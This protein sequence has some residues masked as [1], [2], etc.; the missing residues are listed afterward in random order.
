VAIAALAVI[1]VISIEDSSSSSAWGAIGTAL[2]WGSWLV[3]LAEVVVMLYLV[4]DRKAWIVRH[5]LDVAITVL[6]PPFLPFVG[7]RLLRLLRVLR[8]IFGGVKLSRLLSLEGIR[9][10]GVVVLTT[11]IAGG[12]AFKAAESQQH[13]STWDGIW[14]AMTTVTTVGY[15]DMYPEGTTGR[16]IAMLI[17]FVGIGFVALV[18]AFIAERFIK[19]DVEAEEAEVVSKED[20][21]LAELQQLRAEVA[22]LREGAP[23]P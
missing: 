3:F 6:T 2:N 19:E 12:A 22:E 14:W 10:A 7:A 1:P 5:P 11:V 4:E 8:L 17:M 15:G 13:L 21:I 9:V 20:Q 16:L 23:G 18:T